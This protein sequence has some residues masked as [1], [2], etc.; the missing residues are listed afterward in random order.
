[1]KQQLFENYKTITAEDGMVLTP[2]VDG[3]DI[4]TYS[5]ARLVI[6]PLDGGND[7]REITEEEHLV[8]EKMFEEAVKKLE[9][10]EK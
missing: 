9:E 6:A 5:Y 8:Y 7:Y 10:T 4:T 2:Y 3:G 1:M